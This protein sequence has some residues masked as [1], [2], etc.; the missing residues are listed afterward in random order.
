[1]NKITAGAV[2]SFAVTFGTV[3]QAWALSA[4]PGTAATATPEPLYTLPP[5]PTPAYTP[6]GPEFV[7]TP[8]I[9]TLAPIPPTPNF[10][11]KRAARICAALIRQQRQYNNDRSKIHQQ[12]DGIR[13]QIREL[14]KIK[15]PL[16]AKEAAERLISALLD[17]WTR[18]SDQLAWIRDTIEEIRGQRR[19]FNC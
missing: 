12:I 18:L 6:L 14:S 10:D 15:S 2:L 1:M 4:Q 11:P 16:W 5:S 8:P 19:H 9:P 17:Y 3:F 7:P 13:K